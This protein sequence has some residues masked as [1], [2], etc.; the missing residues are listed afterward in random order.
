MLVVSK[1]VPVAGEWYPPDGVM[2]LEFGCV[3]G[4]PRRGCGIQRTPG[5]KLMVEKRNK[6]YITGCAHVGGVLSKGGV[7][8]SFYAVYEY[9][10]QDDYFNTCLVS[11]GCTPYA[12]VVQSTCK[13]RLVYSLVFV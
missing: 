5:A 1:P 13:S 7:L 12:R 3:S 2:I 11:I 6:K 8:S 9:E 4:I 10:H